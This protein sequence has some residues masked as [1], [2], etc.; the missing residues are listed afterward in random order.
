MNY[1][2]QLNF[3]T[4]ILLIFASL[5]GIC[6]K[7]YEYKSIKKN[8]QIIKKNADVVERISD[9]LKKRLDKLDTDG[10]T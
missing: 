6:I 8:S 5:I 4:N 3:I 10:P 9:K 1:A 7:I 2:Y